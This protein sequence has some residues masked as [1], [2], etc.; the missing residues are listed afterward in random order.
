MGQDKWDDS[1]PGGRK[2]GEQEE[3]HRHIDR[4]GD[5]TVVKH[6]ATLADATAD[7]DGMPGQTVIDNRRHDNRRRIDRMGTGI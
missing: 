7:D 6:R 4:R 3:E 5:E 2:P 1:A